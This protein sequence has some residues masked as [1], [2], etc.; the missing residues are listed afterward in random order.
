MSLP[1]YAAEAS[2][3]RTSRSYQGFNGGTAGNAGQTVVAQQFGG[4]LGLR[5]QDSCGLDYGACLLG[6]AF[7]SG[8][9]MAVYGL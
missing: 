2:L 1:E 6:C 3:Y 5:C 4:L 7:A 8:P 9:L